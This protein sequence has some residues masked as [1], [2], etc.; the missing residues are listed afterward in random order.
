MRFLILLLL[1]LV[2][3]AREAPIG[4]DEIQSPLNRAEVYREALAYSKTHDGFVSKIDAFSDS[5]SMGMGLSK[6]SWHVFVKDFDGT[7]V[8]DIV[9]VNRDGHGIVHQ[10]ILKEG[11]RMWTKGTNNGKP[12]NFWVDRENYKG[13]L[14][15]QFYYR[16]TEP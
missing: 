13:T 6:H 11:D 14:I 3:C 7:R 5:N 15:A 16:N 12:D 8:G 9:K 1:L 4:N 2:C 10:V